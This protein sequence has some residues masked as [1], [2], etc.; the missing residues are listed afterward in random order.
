MRRVYIDTPFGQVHGRLA[1][2]E[3]PW[4]VLHHESPLSSMVFERALPYLG[5]W[6]RVF[7]P[8]TPG[9]GQSDP[10]SEPLDIPTYAN[11]LLSAIDVVTHGQS[12][13]VG[14]MHTGASLA[15]EVA[16]QRE[17]LATHLV[18][19]GLPVYEG[20]LRSEKLR[21]TPPQQP[22][23]D[24]SHLLWVWA[25]YSEIWTDPPLDL[26]HRACVD[27]LSVLE[28]YT[29]AYHAAFRYNPLPS[30]TRFKGAIQFILAE[31]GPLTP[32]DRRNAELVGARIDRVPDLAGQVPYRTPQL[33]AQIVQRFVTD[34]GQSFG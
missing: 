12:F 28:R 13:A 3:G 8:D 29:W 15:V 17:S 2:S 5:E 24:G 14:G 34:P 33:F 11:R 4:L 19:M 16:Q 10:P 23:Q 25:R 9:Y 32:T 21:G 1:G 26:M 7:A 22:R 20:E 31:N 30:L 6:C 27:F 18:L